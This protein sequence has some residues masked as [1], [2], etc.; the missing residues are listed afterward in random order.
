MH[1]RTSG[2]TDA[3]SSGS[4]QCLSVTAAPGARGSVVVDV[5]G[6]VDTFTAPLLEACLRSQATRPG[7]RR[8]VVD[9]GRVTFLGLA[10]VSALA[11]AD[12]RC[13]RHGARL[14]VRS[15]GR[16]GVLRPLQLTGLASRVS[17]DV[18]EPGTRG[19][20]TPVRPRPS[21]PRAPA[22]RPQHVCR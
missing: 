2:V 8:L 1:A 21:P 12:R 20:R 5:A 4:E 9:L 17:V 16:S 7:L 11:R 14:V 3:A 18:R 6:E 10:G 22:R 19:P 15:G 13:S